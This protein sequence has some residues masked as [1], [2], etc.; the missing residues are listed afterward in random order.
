MEH[1]PEEAGKVSGRERQ[2]KRPERGRGQ[3]EPSIVP[4]KVGK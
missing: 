2:V 3:S 1:K 4:E